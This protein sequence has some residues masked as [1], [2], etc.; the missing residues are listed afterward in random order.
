MSFLHDAFHKQP[1]IPA[2]LTKDN[3]KECLSLGFYLLS[4]QPNHPINRQTY[5]KYICFGEL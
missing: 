1:Q 2:V 4:S 5:S 3:W